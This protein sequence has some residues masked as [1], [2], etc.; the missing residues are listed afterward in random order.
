[1]RR[2]TTAL[3][4]VA[5]SAVTAAGSCTATS[6][7]S[8]TAVPA[9]SLEQELVHGTDYSYGIPV[10]WTGVDAQGEPQPDSMITPTDPALPYYIAVDRVF[11]VGTRS[12]DDVVAQLRA[13]FTGT[14]DLKAAPERQV[15]GLAGAGI[16]VDDPPRTRHAYAIVVHAERVF[17]IRVTYDPDHEGE[18]LAVFHAV[19]DSWTWD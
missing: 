13:G 10:G 1:M 14:G 16:V 2:A 7:S 3:V 19:L 6:S 15:A 12:L 18:A 8:E 5:L 11:A 9:V 4:G 17:P